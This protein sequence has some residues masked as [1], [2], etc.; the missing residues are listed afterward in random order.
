MDAKIIILIPYYSSSVAIF[1]LIFSGLIYFKFV[2][3]YWED[4]LPTPL[5]FYRLM[6]QREVFNGES[7]MHP[8]ASSFLSET[9]LCILSC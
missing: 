6:I 2:H 9:M 5:T 4:T 1:Q 7:G 8:L 3:Y